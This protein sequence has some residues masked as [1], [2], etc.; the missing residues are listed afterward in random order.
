MDNIE[1]LM[2]FGLT[3]QEASIYILLLL[4]GSLNGYEVSKRSGI[5]RSNAYNALAGLVEKGAAYVIE[6][7]AVRYLPVAIEELT[8]NKIELLTRAADTLKKQLPKR[9]EETEN[10]ITIKGKRQIED[11]LRNLIADTKERIYLSF[12]S[13]RMKQY[14]LLLQKLIDTNIK[15]VIITDS[16]FTLEGATVYYGEKKT[17]QLRVISDS[18]YVLTGNIQDEYNATCLYSSNN[19]LVEVFKEALANEIKLIQLKEGQE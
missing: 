15:V 7:Q 9:R 8:K 1:L 19:N 12:S 4:E 13:E 16:P 3:R 18:C 14:E 2:K 11:K 6:E 10:Y 5:S 17:E